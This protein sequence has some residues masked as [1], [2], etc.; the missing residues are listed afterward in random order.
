MA[1]TRGN[2]ALNLIQ[3]YKALG[4][5]WLCF[6]DSQGMPAPPSVQAS[7][8][9]PG[10]ET[11]APSAASAKRTAFEFAGTESADAGCPGTELVRA[12]SAR[13]AAQI[14]ARPIESVDEEGQ[15]DRRI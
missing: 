6:C 1:T 7:F 5:G 10:P 13:A 4:G 9:Q 15:R 12:E 14:G 3:L 8:G 11:Q 2:I